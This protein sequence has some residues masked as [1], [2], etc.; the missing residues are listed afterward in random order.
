MI[1]L[2]AKW[3]RKT[4]KMVAVRCTRKTAKM[5]VVK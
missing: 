4:V 5:V 1:K 3:I 2:A